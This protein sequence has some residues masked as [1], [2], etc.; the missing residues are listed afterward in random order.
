M[1]KDW[2]KQ[3]IEGMFFSI[4]K[5]VYDKPRANVIINGEQLN[6]VPLKLEMR[7]GY[8]LSPLLFTTA[9]E[10]LDRTIREE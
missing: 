10:F 4:I 2:K 5:T 8:P 9:L 7:Q 1:I 3:K 6:L